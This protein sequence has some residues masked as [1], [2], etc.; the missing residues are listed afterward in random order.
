MAI[1]PGYYFRE[2]Y[3]LLLMPSVC[4]LSAAAI[5]EIRHLLQKPVGINIS[6]AIS[7]IVM[8][9]AAMQSIY[10]QR[11]YFFEKDPATISRMIFSTNC[12][13]EM[14]EISKYIKAHSNPDDKIGI[15]GSEPEICFYSQRR[16]ATAYIYM[17]PLMENQPYAEKM[18]SEA[19]KQ[20]EDSR[21]RY[22]IF[23]NNYLSWLKQPSSSEMIFRW[24][25]QYYKQYY[26]QVGLVEYYSPDKIEYHWNEEIS[27]AQKTVNI[28]IFERKDLPM[29]N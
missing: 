15:L 3:F 4:I 21:P 20:I 13:P 2:H 14:I 18:Q 23:I 27:P 19:I 12:F 10:A 24:F 26:K 17:Y 9:A 1:C 8:L 7:I 25:S 6:A 29:D 22:L 5:C 16:S 11:N 28:L